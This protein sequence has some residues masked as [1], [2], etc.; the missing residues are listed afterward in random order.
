M[1]SIIL[2]FVSSL[3]LPFFISE[4]VEIADNKAN[5]EITIEILN[6]EALDFDFS[7]KHEATR[8]QIQIRSNDALRSLRLMDGNKKKK[9]YSIIG[10]NLVVL[11]MTDFVAGDEHILEVKFLTTQQVVVAKLNV[12]A[13]YP[14]AVN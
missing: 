8:K 12:P 7:I 2:F 1:K 6:Q 5:T 9:S 13:D 10:S 11:P 3:V 14:M 4:G